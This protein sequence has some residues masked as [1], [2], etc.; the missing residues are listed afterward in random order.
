MLE[1]YTTEVPVWIAW[2]NLAGYV[3][4]VPEKAMKIVWDKANNVGWA[5]TR[6]KGYP[7]T[8]LVHTEDGPSYILYWRGTN[9]RNTFVR[10]GSR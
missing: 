9:G 4:Y 10:D 8:T 7:P 5:S 2:N 6:L 3:G 1:P